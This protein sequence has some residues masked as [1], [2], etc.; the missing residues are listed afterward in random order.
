MQRR[1][2]DTLW[3]VSFAHLYKNECVLCANIC[4]M[5]VGLR[6]EKIEYGGEKNKRKRK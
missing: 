5:L 6:V 4:A 2:T 3:L 1:F